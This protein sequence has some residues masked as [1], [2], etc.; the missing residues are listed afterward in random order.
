MGVRRR[1]I[2]AHLILPGVQVA[3]TSLHTGGPS[4]LFV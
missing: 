2:R 1:L 3:R 4:G